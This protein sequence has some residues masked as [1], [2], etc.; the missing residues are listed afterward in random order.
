MSSYPVN[1]NSLSPYPS[2]ALND[3]LVSGVLDKGRCRWISHSTLPVQATEP[4]KLAYT[5]HRRE[6]DSMVDPA[7]RTLTSY[8]HASLMT[9][10]LDRCLNGES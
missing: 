9:D 8:I 10:A 1:P 5:H 3:V 2:E 7:L 6:L 4:A